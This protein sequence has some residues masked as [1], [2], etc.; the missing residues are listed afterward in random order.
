MRTV[1]ELMQAISEAMHPEIDYSLVELGMIKDV[2]I[3]K[4]RVVVTISLPLAGVPIRDDLA[5]IVTEAVAN[6]DDTLQVEVQFATMNQ[7]ERQEFMEKA[8]EK[9]KF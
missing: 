9:W 8:R 5:R 3:D 4:G 2:G 7:E 6:E 1:E